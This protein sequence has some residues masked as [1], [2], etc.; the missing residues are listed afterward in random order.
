MINFAFVELWNQRVGEATWDQNQEFAMFKYDKNFWKHEWNVSPINMPVTKD[1]NRI[2]AFPML[3]RSGVFK[4]LPG[5]LADALPDHYG[6]EL[7][8]SWL[9]SQGREGE[10]NPI[11]TLCFIGTRGMGALE[12]KPAYLGLS[13][14]AEKI[15]VSDLVKIAN[16]IL[17]GRRDFSSRML[18]DE[19]K[20]I[21]EIFKIGTS[22]GGARP[23]AIIAYN[24]K[25]N[26]VRSGQVDA[27]PG[28]SHWIIKF[29][30]IEDGNLGPTLGY[31]RIEMAYS[32]MTRACGID[33]TECR[34][35]EENGRAHFM[36]RRFD[37]KDNNKIHVQ[38]WGSMTNH[39][40]NYSSSY[41]DLFATMRKLNVPSFDFYEVYLRMVFNVMAVNNDDHAK[42][43]AFL[44]DKDGKWR[45]SPAYD[46]TYNL[47]RKD[48]AVA[49]H[50]SSINGKF[51]NV[52]KEDLM[53][54][55]KK[56]NIYQPEKM[57]KKVS[58]V[59]NEWPSYARAQKVD[60]LR[61][62]KINNLIIRM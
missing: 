41:E 20:Y 58:E 18:P 39:D 43:F 2:F 31:G 29:D 45:L 53:V 36:T 23:K 19:N 48:M 55:A 61:L 1:V 22:V 16:D 50:I 42:N 52:T 5:L 3:R 24:P 14:Y 13:T 10:L 9:H 33:M 27:P 15:N 8:T 59:V 44:M 49:R 25:T 38:S 47:K 35:F 56:M 51:L 54:F 62:E 26:E 4:G 21:L 46:V 11:E 12:F 6:N 57:I 30:G 37:R 17:T 28:F 7:I 40:F 60:P 34:L 32:E